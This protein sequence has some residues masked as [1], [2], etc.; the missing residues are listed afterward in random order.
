MERRSRK[1]GTSGDGLGCIN[2]DGEEGG[3]CRAG[4]DGDWWRTELVGSGSF[5]SQVAHGLD[6]KGGRNQGL[7][8]FSVP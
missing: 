2:T 7:E 8:K 4:E 1:E 5:S 6:R 3:G